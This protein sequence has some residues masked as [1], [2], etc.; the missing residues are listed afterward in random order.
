MRLIALLTVFFFGGLAM[1][2]EITPADLNPTPPT[3]VIKTA[4]FAGGC[5]WCMQPA[6][7]GTPGVTGTIVGYTGGASANPTY[8]EVSS[9]KS[10]HIE[11]IEVTYDENRV[12]YNRL[13]EIYWEN[14]DPTD[15]GGQF[16]DRG[17]QYLTAI[18]V[19]DDSQRAAAEESK[20]AVQ[21][22]FNAQ[23]IVT[24]IVAA[25][26]FYPA[27]DYHQKYYQKNSARYTMYK[28]GSGRANKLEQLWGDTKK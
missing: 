18:Y 27:E 16:A 23:K 21:K 14:V 20:V 2:Q 6:F 26:P 3:P 1:A 9:G 28:Y 10:G 8:E 11:A 15:K 19:A 12:K 13:L 5:F 17:S 22:K 24:T 4:I 25:S 7:D